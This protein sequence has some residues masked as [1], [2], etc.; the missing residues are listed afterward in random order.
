VLRAYRDWT[1][2]TAEELTATAMLLQ[3]PPT[4]DVPEPLRGRALA[5]VGAAYIGS[6]SDEPSWSGR[7]ANSRPRWL[8]ASK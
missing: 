4:P 2:H 7:C 6:A 8:T 3:L 1:Q 5:H